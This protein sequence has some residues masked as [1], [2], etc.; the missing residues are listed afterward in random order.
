M[1]DQDDD[2]LL[3]QNQLT[4]LTVRCSSGHALF[5]FRCKQGRNQGKIYWKSSHPDC[6]KT[7]YNNNDIMALAPYDEPDKTVKCMGK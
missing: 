7:F 3:L 4:C 1:S 6:R 5:F 2:W